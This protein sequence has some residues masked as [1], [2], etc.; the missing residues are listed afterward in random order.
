MCELCLETS[1]VAWP[2]LQV[3]F[4][5]P[6]RGRVA[7]ITDLHMNPCC[8]SFGWSLFKSA[9]S[10]S[11]CSALISIVLCISP[12]DTALC[13][14]APGS[15]HIMVRSLCVLPVGVGAWYFGHMP[16][17][18][19]PPASVCIHASSARFGI[20][21]VTPQGYRVR[22]TF[23][24][25]HSWLT[26]CHMKAHDLQRFLHATFAVCDIKPS[27]LGCS[28]C[29]FM[30]AASAWLGVPLLTDIGWIAPG[31]EVVGQ[32]D[33]HQLSDNGANHGSEGPRV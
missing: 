14:D 28:I 4:R 23:K 27:Q 20:H 1:A 13:S 26:K 31:G 21:F 10:S 8:V 19:T 12:M 3:M 5:E 15:S 25:L 16:V 6:S 11:R 32:R 30:C 33:L 9:L 29:I 7:C 22:R 18:E 24:A 2:V 17:F